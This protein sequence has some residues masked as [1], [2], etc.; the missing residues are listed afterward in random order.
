VLGITPDALNLLATKQLN[1]IP[2]DRLA[3]IRKGLAKK[4]ML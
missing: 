1:V 2:D 3:K 4:Y